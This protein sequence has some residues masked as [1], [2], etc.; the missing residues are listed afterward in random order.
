[1]VIIV[2]SNH[3]TAWKEKYQEAQNLES[4]DLECE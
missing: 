3:V 1:M 4:H 2:Y